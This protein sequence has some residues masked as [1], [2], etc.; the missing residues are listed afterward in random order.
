MKYTIET[1]AGPRRYWPVLL[2]PGEDGWVIARCPLFAG[3]L[4]QGQ[5]RAEALDNIREAI[6][7]CVEEAEAEDTPL[8][9]EVEIVGIAC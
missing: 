9:A 8:P 3:C 2:I 7:L 5:T 1:E 4:T 6:A